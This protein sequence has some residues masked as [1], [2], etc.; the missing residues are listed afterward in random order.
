MLALSKL[1]L[2]CVIATTYSNEKAE[3]DWTSAP[4]GEEGGDVFGVPLKLRTTALKE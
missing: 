3:D 2:S 1:S 4:S